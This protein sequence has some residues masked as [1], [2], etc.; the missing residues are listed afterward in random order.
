[1]TDD[2][3]VPSSGH[4]RRNFLT[5]AGATAGVLA[6][7]AVIGAPDASATTVCPTDVKLCPSGDTSGATDTAALNAAITTLGAAGLIEASRGVFYFNAAVTIPDG[8]NIV[9]A[10]NNL[11]DLGSPGTWFKLVSTG[12]SLNFAGSGGLSGQ[13]LVDGTHVATTPLLR[14]L[15]AERTFICIDV[16]RSARDN[17]VINQAQNDLYISC[18]SQD[19]A[20]DTLVLDQGCGG[21]EFDR[22]EANSAGRYLVNIQQTGTGPY[23]DEPTH[24]AFR[25]SIFENNVAQNTTVATAIKATRGLA[26]GFHDCVFAPHLDPAGSKNIITIENFA[27]LSFTDCRFF[28]L[29][30]GLSITGIH[31]EQ[32]GLA[33]LNGR[34]E[35]LG[36]SNGALDFPVG[37]QVNVLGTMKLYST[38]MASTSTPEDYYA[39]TYTYNPRFVT[40]KTSS[41]L[42]QQGNV[43]GEA[44]MRFRDYIDGS[45]GYVFGGTSYT[46]GGLFGATGANGL[47]NLTGSLDGAMSTVPITAAG[48]VNIDASKGNTCQVW[49]FANSTSTV[50]TNAHAGMVLRIQYA[51]LGGS[52]PYAWVAPASTKW[53]GG[54]APVRTASTQYANDIITLVFDGT[55]WCEVGRSLN[56]T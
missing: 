20:R 53:V 18:N 42:V 11:Y 55:S 31:L 54:V 35:F 44:G 34:A 16:F 33:T 40:R 17:W 22:F 45:R 30:A 9:G 25:H 27:E 48:P 28:G 1:M 12:A 13:F 4:S 39:G 56:V 37:A 49:L 46:I 19:A 8:I 43:E 3:A 32:Y 21:L 15:G 24:I 14:S 50:I 47:G 41:Q 6:T 52:P 2:A 29:D 26:I 51:Q 10:G 7:G 38:P 5:I 36:C 23:P